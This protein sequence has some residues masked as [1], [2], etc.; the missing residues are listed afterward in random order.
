MLSAQIRYQYVAGTTDIHVAE[1]SGE[2]VYHAANYALAGFAK[3]TWLYGDGAFHPFFSLAAGLGR[4]RHVV[5]FQSQL[6]PTCGP[7]RNEVCKDTIGAGPVLLGPGAGVMYDLGDRASLV[8]QLNSVLGFP[9][10]TAHV[11]ANLGVAVNF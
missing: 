3:A 5:S 6:A 9:T 11:D 8:V 10:F 7:S 4:I 1:G 2:R